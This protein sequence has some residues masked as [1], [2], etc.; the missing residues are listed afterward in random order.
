MAGLNTRIEKEQAMLKSLAMGASRTAAHKAAGV[1]HSTLYNWLKDSPE[2][3]AAV[4]EAEGR[5]IQSVAHGLYMTAITPGVTGQVTACIFF[6]KNK[7]PENW[8]DVYDQRHSGT[9]GHVNLG[10]IIARAQVLEKS[11]PDEMKAQLR[12]LA[13]EVEHGGKP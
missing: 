13:K 5:A 1:S 12:K 3:K 9:V 4:E 8:R 2:F 11:L 6:L 7:D 10:T